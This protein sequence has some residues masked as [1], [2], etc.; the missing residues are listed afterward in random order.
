MTPTAL[1]IPPERIWWT[2]AAWISC[3]MGRD[4]RRVRVRPWLVK[5]EH[6]L[7]RIEQIQGARRHEPRW[8]ILLHRSR[9]AEQQRQDRHHG[10]VVVL[11]VVAGVA[12]VGILAV[13]LRRCARR[14][15]LVHEPLELPVPVGGELRQDVPPPR[16]HPLAVGLVDQ[17]E[18]LPQRAQRKKEVGRHLVARAR[19]PDHV[20]G[21]DPVLVLRYLYH[22]SLG[23]GSPVAE[24]LVEGVST[25]SWVASHIQIPP[26]E[27]PRERH[28]LIS[29]IPR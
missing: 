16:K 19:L 28:R 17:G 11:D 1:G 4:E 14:R 18:R 27:R 13:G 2:L 5:S 24:F 9:P 25:P 21:N 26:V 20:Q 10:V 23:A 3:R 6:V 7:D 29:T 15:G 22:P 12:S 8:E